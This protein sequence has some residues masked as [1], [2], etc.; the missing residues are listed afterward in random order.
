VG[1]KFS[2]ATEALAAGT[3]AGEAP[4]IAVELR[5]GAGDWAGAVEAAGLMP[6]EAR[7]RVWRDLIQRLDRGCG[8]WMAWPG[9]ALGEG[10]MWRY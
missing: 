10:V 8:A 2:L 3:W 4:E 7:M 1:I 9:Q 5:A 6:P